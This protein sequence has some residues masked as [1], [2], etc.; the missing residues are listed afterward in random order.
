MR[1]TCDLT[2]EQIEVGY[3]LTLLAIHS[4]FCKWVVELEMKITHFAIFWETGED[5]HPHLYATVDLSFESVME[6]DPKFLDEM[7]LGGKEDA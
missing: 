7:R 3:D 1:L 6:I 5:G 4:R 2:Q